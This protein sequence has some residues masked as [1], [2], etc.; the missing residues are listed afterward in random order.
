MK[1]LNFKNR[2][3]ALEYAYNNCPFDLQKLEWEGDTG[4]Y[5]ESMDKDLKESIEKWTGQKA[6]DDKMFLDVIFVDKLMD[7]SNPSTTLEILSNKASYIQKQILIF[8]QESSNLF[9]ETLGVGKH[10]LPRDFYITTNTKG[11]TKFYLL[12]EIKIDYQPYDNKKYNVVLYTKDSMFTINLS[13]IPI[14]RVIGLMRE[15]GV[16]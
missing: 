14:F 3:E 13:E 5:F 15:M 4:Y 2:K 6:G 11:N 9:G 16:K 10:S 12:S 8:Y 7:N 1:D